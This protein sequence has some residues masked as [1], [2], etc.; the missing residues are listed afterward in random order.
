MSSTLRETLLGVSR[1]PDG[2]SPLEVVEDAIF[3]DGAIFYR[4]GVATTGPDGEEV[5]GAGRSRGLLLSV[6]GISNCLSALQRWT[7]CDTGGTA[8]T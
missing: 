5:T 3:A 4:A 7:L 6:V 8:T 1:L 2:W